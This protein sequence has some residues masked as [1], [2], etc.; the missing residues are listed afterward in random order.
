MGMELS[1]V[2]STSCIAIE[3][4]PSRKRPVAGNAGLVERVSTQVGIVPQALRW[5]R[6]RR[7]LVSRQREVQC[8]ANMRGM[9]FALSLHACQVGDGL[10]SRVR[11]AKGMKMKMKM[12]MTHFLNVDLDLRASSN[13]KIQELVRALEPSVLV[14]N[15]SGDFASLE[16]AK[17]PKDIDS[18]VLAFARLVKSLPKNTRAI[19]ERCGMKAMNIGIRAGKEPFASVFDIS[20]RSIRALHELGATLKFTVYSP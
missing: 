18:A 7:G 16:L 6:A 20:R 15:I 10:E 8:R 17:G 13:G 9:C 11:P 5:Y 14:M 1:A 2:P 3:I 12:K 4:G 19:W